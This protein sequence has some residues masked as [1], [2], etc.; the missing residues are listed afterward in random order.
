MTRKRP[1]RYRLDAQLWRNSLA[2]LALIAVPHAI[3]LRPPGD[4][5][6][7]EP[8]AGTEKP[9]VV[10]TLNWFTELKRRMSGSAVAVKP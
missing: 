7:T 2:Q 4:D 10:V 5:S 3:N 6:V 9:D 8:Q 1:R